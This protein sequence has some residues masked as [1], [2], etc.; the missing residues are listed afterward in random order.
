MGNLRLPK[1]GVYPWASWSTPATPELKRLKCLWIQGQTECTSNKQTNNE[2]KLSV[3]G[4]TVILK[5]MRKR[6]KTVLSSGG[7]Y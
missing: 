6:P 1:I 7:K 2:N 3:A 4:H 5:L